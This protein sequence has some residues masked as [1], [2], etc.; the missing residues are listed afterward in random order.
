MQVV[1]LRLKL[2]EGE[3]TNTLDIEYSI[4][5]SINHS[6]SLIAICWTISPCTVN[7]VSIIILFI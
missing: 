7:N 1:D 3:Q 4:F 5:L 2:N 6:W